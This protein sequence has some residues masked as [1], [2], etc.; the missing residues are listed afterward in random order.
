MLLIAIFYLATD[1]TDYNGYFSC[2]DLRYPFLKEKT[3]F[4]DQ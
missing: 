2:G 3:Y 1:C 4:T